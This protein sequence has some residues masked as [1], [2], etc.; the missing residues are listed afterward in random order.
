MSGPV[1][2][3]ETPTAATSGGSYAD[4]P[5]ALW[6]LTAVLVA[7]ACTA[8]LLDAAI[9]PEQRIALLTQSGIFP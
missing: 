2:F 8:L 6:T 4:R 1:S 5:L 3:I 7:I 9:T